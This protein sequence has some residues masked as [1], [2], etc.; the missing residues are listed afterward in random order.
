MRIF[1]EIEKQWLRLSKK[2]LKPLRKNMHCLE[3][4]LLKMARKLYLMRML[5]LNR[6]LFLFRIS[7]DIQNFLIR[8]HLTE[9]LNLLRKR[10][11][12]ISDVWTQIVFVSLQIMEMF[13]RLRHQPFQ[14]RR[15][16][17]KGYLLIILEITVAKVKA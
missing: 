10:I 15:L 13:I 12:I 5:L 8:Q 17:R 1:L 11:N 2:I 9:T 14:L 4:L 6:K 3:R 7:L 16:G